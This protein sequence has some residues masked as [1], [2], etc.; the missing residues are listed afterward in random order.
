MNACG[1]RA[2]AGFRRID[3][4]MFALIAV[5]LAL[6]PASRTAA[7]QSAAGGGTFVLTN[8]SDPDP[9]D[10]ALTSHTMSRTFERNVYEAL[11]YY[12]LGTTEL[13]PVLAEKW[14]VSPDG[15]TY[16]FTLRQGVKFQNGADFTANDVKATFDRD[17]ALKEG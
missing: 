2:H 3:V 5:L 1:S 8:L 11:V 10:P 17:L 13:E 12:K 6:A 15:L 4:L 16:T 9:I 7:A 14:D